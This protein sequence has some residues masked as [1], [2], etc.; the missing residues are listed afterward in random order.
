MDKLERQTPSRQLDRGAIRPIAAI[1]DDWHAASSA[2]DELQNAG[3]NDDRVGIA[4]L[5]ANNDQISRSDADLADVNN[6]DK[7]S[8]V[9]SG[10]GTGVVVGGATGLLAALASLFI[11][12]I[13]PVV[14]GGVLATTLA[15]AAGIG[16]SIGAVAGGIIAALTSS[17]FS[18]EE[19]HYYESELRRGSTLVTV[20]P[21]ERDSE[22]IQILQRNGGRMWVR[23]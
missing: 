9:V 15:T 22:A 8:D 18:E 19:A 6:N 21:G 14:A 1:F 23:S 4:R 3:F 7:T 11:P 10:I 13:G 17:G 12:G 20:S 16:A 5:D 2:V